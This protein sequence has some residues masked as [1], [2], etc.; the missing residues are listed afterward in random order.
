MN[1]LDCT[2]DPGSSTF[3]GPIE[4][5][6]T[7]RLAT[8]A[9]DAGGGRVT[10]GFRP[11]APTVA[12]DAGD[13]A[14]G[15]SGRVDVVEPVGERSFVYVTLSAGPQVTVATPGETPGGRPGPRRAP[16]G[17]RSPLRRRERRGA[18]PPGPRRLE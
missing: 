9:A 18:P 1:L 3:G 14:P 16:A 13:G 12:A 11:E 10:L 15:F 7:D 2:F 6:A 8:A 4:Y 17:R 5:P